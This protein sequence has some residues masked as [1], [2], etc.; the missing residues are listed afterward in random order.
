MTHEIALI[1]EEDI[2]EKIYN[3]RGYDVLLD[4]D[5]AKYYGYETKAFNQQVQRNINRFDNDFMFQL[6]EE[7]KINILR[8]QNV[9]S[10]FNNYGGR[11]YL[12][13]AF[14]EQGIYMLMTVLK[15]Q[16]AIEQ[17]KKLIRLFKKMKDYMIKNDLIDQKYINNLV[18]KQQDILT[19]H[20]N[21]ISRI[22]NV[23]RNK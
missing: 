10:S 2:K 21:R 23:N 15:G 11:R 8:S 1:T 4:S 14:T 6:T 22:E 17:S 3:I 20:E 5:L 19:K 13:Y 9:T 12:P 18:L 16:K 7:E